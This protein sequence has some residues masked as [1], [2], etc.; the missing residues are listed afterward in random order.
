MVMMRSDIVW[1][2]SLGRLSF[3]KPGKLVLQKIVI[4]TARRGSE[5]YAVSM[6]KP[7]AG[8]RRKYEHQI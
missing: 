4:S 7:A 6:P 3:Q 2:L 8:G 1:G 5:Q